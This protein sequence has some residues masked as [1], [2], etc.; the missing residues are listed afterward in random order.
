ME[1]GARIDPA[2]QVHP[3][4]TIGAGAQ[5]GPRVKIGE[6]AVVGGD[7]VIDGE[8]TEI[9]RDAKVGDNCRVHEAVIEWEAEL[10]C[11]CSIE[12]GV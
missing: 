12:S 7:C 9:Q 4:A 6:N 3:S 2:A 1:T 10:G 11:G 5:V 8:G